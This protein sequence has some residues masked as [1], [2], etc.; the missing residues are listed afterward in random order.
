MG[1]SK[2][3]QLEICLIKTWNK[4]DAC[5]CNVCL[6]V[7]RIDSL[8]PVNLELVLF[9]RQSQELPAVIANSTF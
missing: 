8:T 7:G 3:I 6:L 5:V 1:V 4:F 2:T 9:R